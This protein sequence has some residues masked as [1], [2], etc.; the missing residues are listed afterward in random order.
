VPILPSLKVLLVK[1][2]HLGDFAVTLPVL[3]E[4][5]GRFGRENVA[6]MAGR[7]NAEWA[8]LLRWLPPITPVDHP[9]YVRRAGTGR[10]W[11]GC[12]AAWGLR[13]RRFDYGVELT[14]SRH[15]IWGKTWLILAGARRRSG[16]ADKFR[17]LVHEHHD[18]GQGHQ[19]ER[20][21]Q[22][23]PTA[24]GI[25]GTARPEAFIPPALRWTPEARGLLLAPFAG[26]PA[27]EGRPA[28]WIEL[29]QRLKGE[30]REI[31]LF[32]GP[33]RADDARHLLAASGLPT[34]GLFLPTSIRATLE[35]LA[36]TGALL[37]PDTAI[38]HY[39]WLTGT[40]LVQLF[41]DT[42]DPAR[43]GSLGASARLTAPAGMDGIG[44][45][46]VLAALREA[47]RARD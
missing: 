2:D 11:A 34:D 10:P 26:R 46:A 4:L 12:R 38:A 25:T 31:T 30:G 32:A 24:W 5:A 35:R 19:T 23:F 43:W 29:I 7:A 1:P 45:E 40:P 20:M 37:A 22:R 41:A 21:A 9:R 8:A 44:V 42:D 17:L 13:G 3:W 15:D 39:A 28:F 6:V 36:R 27:K 18:L 16:L 33:E 14:S 47:E